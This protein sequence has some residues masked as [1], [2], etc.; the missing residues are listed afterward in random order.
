MSNGFYSNDPL[1]KGMTKALTNH[2]MM[3]YDPKHYEKLK[4]E[5][6]GGYNLKTFFHVWALGG[7]VSKKY[8]PRFRW[9]LWTSFM[10]LPMRIIENIRF[11]RKIRQTKIEK[12]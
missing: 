12:D 7:R 1:V 2:P 11:Q 10:T 4:S 9:A 6:M 8:R 3:N 5:P